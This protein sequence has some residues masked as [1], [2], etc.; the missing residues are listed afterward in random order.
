MREFT[1]SEEQLCSLVQPI[2]LIGSEVD[3]LLPS[4]AEVQRLAQI[5]P[6]AQVELLPHS[7]H[8]CLLEADVNLYQIMKT[9]RF[10]EPS[11]VQSSEATV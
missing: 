1:V 2:L 4:V 5:L 6:D 10:L 3:I 11:C 7:G 9:Q 8:A